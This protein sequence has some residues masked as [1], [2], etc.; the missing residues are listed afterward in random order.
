MWWLSA[1]G[2]LSVLASGLLGLDD[3][4]HVLERI[5]SVLVFLVAVTIIAGLADSAK[6]FD[7]AAREAAHLARGR[8][9][10]L[11]LLVVVLATA[12][13]IVLSL[14]TCAVLLTPVV[15]AM[16]RQLSIPPKLFAF[17]TVW[18]AGTASLLLP[19]SNLTNLLALHR[20]DQ[21][22]L[23]LGDYL[24]LSWRPAVAAVLVTVIVLAA[25]FHRDLRRAYV[26]PK[27]PAVDDKV[28][29]WGA[30][31]VCLALGPAFV[32]GV[33]VAWPASAGAVV[34][35]GLFAVRRRAAVNWSL[36]PWRL[37][38]T[39]V[40][41]FLVVA[42]LT[43]HGFEQRLADVAGTASGG[44][45]PDLRL[46]GTAAIGANAVDNLP[47]YLAMEPVAAAEGRR[48]MLLLIGVNCGCLLTLW[49]SLATLLWRDRCR[50]AGVHISWWSFL[51]RGAVLV[52]LVLA[53]AVLA[54]R[55][56]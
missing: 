32:S 41:L 30:A 46:A 48:M 28:L 55:L 3:A 21:L 52:P 56:G 10:R 37:V 47:A 22:G 15:L 31:G 29:F 2:G 8:T 17:T 5:A 7:V 53:G 35:L 11:W 24:A 4:V 6:V 38:V 34:L 13:T 9:W 1:L 54:L 16:A 14:D 18:L 36:L 12:L 23:G 19:V 25:L 33:E 40:G 49:G 51:W 20:F 45:L 44:L 43:A 26:V 27:T 50:T 42:T 39:V